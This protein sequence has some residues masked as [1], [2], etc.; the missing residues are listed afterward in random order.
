MALP[1]VDVDLAAVCGTTI[2]ADNVGGL[3]A[4]GG[5]GQDTSAISCTSALRTQH[6][7]H[8]AAALTR[9]PAADPHPPPPTG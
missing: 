8:L 7:R 5:V 4:G 3:P 1:V 6:V 2:P 9:V